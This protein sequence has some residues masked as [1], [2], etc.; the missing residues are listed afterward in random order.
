MSNKTKFGMGLL[1]LGFAPITDEPPAALP[2]YGAAVSLGHAVRAALTV[3]SADVP[4]YGDDMELLRI[5]NFLDGSFET[6]TLMTELELESK[7]YGGTYTAGGGLTSTADDAGTPGAVYGIRKLMKKDKSLVYRAFVLF[8]CAA[9]RSASGWDADTKN[10]TVTPKN[11]AVNFDVSTA[12]NRTWKWEQDFTTQSAARAAIFE[13][14][15]T[16]DPEAE[17]AA[18]ETTETIT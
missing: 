13:T 11:A 7:L 15:G 12:N 18:A 8:R 1:D 16:D 9:N 2:T 4:I 10:N 3:N 6:Q 14:L 5:D 17:S